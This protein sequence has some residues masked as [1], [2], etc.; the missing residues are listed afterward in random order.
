MTSNLGSDW[1][2]ASA[3]SMPAPEMAVRARRNLEAQFRPEFLN[4]IDEVIVFRPLD[5]VD[6][7]RIVS[8]QLARLNRL[9]EPSGVNVEAD[10][11]ALDLLAERGFDPV[12]GARPLKR[13]I[14]RSV[15]NTLASMLLRGELHPGS[16][17][18][19]TV[20]DGEL[21]FHQAETGSGS[22]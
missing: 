9:L 20:E 7:R 12:Y 8:I 11:K 3:G 16:S 19:I 6:L 15:Q 5:A 13:V 4:R 17:V 22:A 14:Q 10:G 1:I 21:S 18:G 2:A